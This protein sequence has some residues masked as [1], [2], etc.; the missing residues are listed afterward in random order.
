MRWHAEDSDPTKDQGLGQRVLV[1]G[2]PAER[3]SAV[4][5]FLADR[6]LHR[7]PR[8]EMPRGSLQKGAPSS[9][10]ARLTIGRLA[11]VGAG[12]PYPSG[13]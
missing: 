4:D 12:A 8:S 9:E 2:P 10:R 11:A 13:S 7:P 6:A 3:S 1:T 5:Q